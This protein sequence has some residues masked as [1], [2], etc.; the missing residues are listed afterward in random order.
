MDEGEKDAVLYGTDEFR[1]YS[2]TPAK[3]A[4]GA[5]LQSQGL[6]AW[7]W[8][9]ATRLYHT[10]CWESSAHQKGYLFQLCR[11]PGTLLKQM[12]WVVENWVLKEP[13]VKFTGLVMG[14]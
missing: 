4:S 9:R 14:E 11:L 1:H 12:L 10:M 6:E 5:E 3:E 7:S 2:R 13:E 8:P